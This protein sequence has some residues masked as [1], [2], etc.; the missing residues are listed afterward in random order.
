MNILPL[1]EGTKLEKD[2]ALALGFFDGVHL[3]HQEIFRRT[4]EAANQNNLTSAAFTFVNHPSE[5]VSGEIVPLLSTFLEKKDLIVPSGI[6]QL[7]YRR[8]MPE[9]SGISA[10]D[11]VEK[12][13]LGQLRAKI[14]VVGENYTFGHRG[15]GDPEFLK[16][17]G[18]QW[19]FKVLVGKTVKAQEQVISSTLIRELVKKGDLVQAA[20]MLGRDYSVRGVINHGPGIGQT[21]GFPTANLLPHLE[22]LLPPNGIYLVRFKVGGEIYPGVANLGFAPTFIEKEFALEVHLLNFSGSIYGEEAEVSFLGYMREEIKFPDRSAL[23]EQIRR[24]V[25]QAVAFFHDN[26]QAL[27]RE[28]WA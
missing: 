7:V 10:R 15:Q 18:A 26:P 14:V 6:Q 23:I 13:L 4:V 2:A 24:D 20:S 9:F 8:F 16:E 28:V 27:R 19:G 25:S 3:G 5:I 1:T 12:I 11:F 21:L 22:K 17:L